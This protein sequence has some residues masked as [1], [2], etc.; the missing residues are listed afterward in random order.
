MIKKLMYFKKIE[1]IILFF[2]ITF[3]VYLALIIGESWDERYDLLHGKT[4]LDYLFSIGKINNNVHYGD[5]YSTAYWSLQHFITQIFP[6]K[7]QIE[8]AHLINLTVSLGAVFG[9]GKLTK[10]IFNKK[11]GKIAFLILFFYPAFFG[12]MAM[13]SKD[14]ILAFC[15]VWIF[16]LLIR[17]LK[18]QHIK[19]KTKQYI[20]SIAIL[21][22][23]ATGIQLVFLGSLITILIFVIVD[24]LFLKK[25]T[26]KNFSKKKFIL[27]LSKCFLIFYLVLIFFWNE[28]HSNI[29]TLPL[30]YFWENIVGT[31][32]RGWPYTLLNG[33]YYFS[34]HVS[35]FY[36]LINLLYKSPEFFLLCYII[37]LY[38]LLIKN[39]FFKNHFNFF[40]Y[41]ILIFLS[42]IILPNLALIFVPYATYDG[43]RLFL[44][45]LPYFCIIPAL[46]IYFLL[47]NYRTVL[48]K[49]ILGI[50]VVLIFYH[51]FNFF[52]LSPYQY[53]YLNI[54]GSKSASEKFENDYWGTSVKELVKKSSFLHEGGKLGVCGVNEQVVKRLLKKNKFNRVKIVNLQNDYDFIIMT[55]RTTWLD[56][57]LSWDIKDKNKITNCFKKFNGTILS[58]VKR[59]DI[60]LSVIK[61]K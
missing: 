5:Y 21:S 24:I 26:T 55:N 31:N 61:K 39:N 6:K 16:Y 59:N 47:Q 54:F 53:A 13:N 36:L 44:W 48:N 15:H 17:Y 45:S 8:I 37:F 7:Y 2:L 49:S 43:M 19:V 12:H 10:E 1:N 3:S 60:L 30:S 38:I 25:F 23:I 56:M 46:T 9:I 58:S 28:T 18:Q 14:T 41:K 4:T 52:A 29:F 22:A 50:I 57:N 40:N 11:V 35:K 51:L 32:W 42:I 34:L 33:D 27:D 20:I